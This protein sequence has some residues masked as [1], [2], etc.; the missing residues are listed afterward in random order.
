LI[1]EKMQ[2][3]SRKNRQDMDKFVTDAKNNQYIIA[4]FT[5]YMYNGFEK[6]VVY[7]K[8]IQ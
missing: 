3:C 1:D 2:K 7:V 8:N 4:A 5:M 6:I